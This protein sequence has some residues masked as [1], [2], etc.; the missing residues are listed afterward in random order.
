V[1]SWRAVVP[2]V[3]VGAA[4][5][6]LGVLLS[7]LAGVSRTVFAMAA[8]GDLPRG[9]AA[10]HERRRIPHRAELVVGGL[11][12]LSAATLDVRQAIGAS[13]FAVLVY[14]AVANAAAWTLPREAR[15]WPRALAGVGLVGCVVLALAL[16]PVAVVV[17]AAVLLAGL[18]GRAVLVR[19]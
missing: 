11:M 2:V 8:A 9:L 16:P 14:Y 19:R 13:S 3:R 15:R 17:G 4:L 12:A 18:L 7:L 5:A 10:V 6:S 1:G